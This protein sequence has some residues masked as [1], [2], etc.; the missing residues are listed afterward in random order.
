MPSTEIMVETR[1]I[2]LS[3]VLR[4]PEGTAKGLILALHGGN[5]SAGYWNY[6]GSRG[7]S[8]MRLGAELGFHVLALDRPG[9]GRS[10]DFE[11]KRLGLAAQVD[12]LFDT[13]DAWTSTHR[14]SGPVFVIGH[15]IGG[16]LT[17]LM[18]AHQRGARLSGVDVLGVPFRFPKTEAGDEVN[19]WST[20]G[21]HVPPPDEAARK[22]LLFGPEGTYDPEAF[23]Y[24][25][26][27]PRPMPVAEYIDALKMPDAWAQVLPAILI[28]VQFTLAEFEVMQATGRDTLRDVEALLSNSPRAR[29][30]L[31]AGSG[32]N[33]ST[34]HIARAYHLRAI[35]FFEECLA[36]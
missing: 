3:G 1:D 22:W 18:A 17:L 27:L 21:T 20:T 12:F 24:D 34:H 9:Y 26:T 29:V 4:S 31:Q 14:F 36:R 6:E 10:Y 7:E 32:H 16:I 13:I 28:P 15:S 2:A 19:S 30:A 25:S 23:A 35:A 5:Y 11:P 8:L 33:A